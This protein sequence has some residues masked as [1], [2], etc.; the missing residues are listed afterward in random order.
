MIF[1][2]IIRKNFKLLIRSKASALIFLVGPLM[3]MLLISLAFN[4]SSLYDI[5]I[6]TYS[7]SY[8]ELSTSIIEKLQ[9]DAFKVVR[10]DSEDKCMESVK[11]G[12]IHVCAI[13]PPDLNIKSQDKIVFYV[14]KSRMNLI[15]VIMG[16]ISSKVS[17][18][19]TELSTLLTN[20]LVNALQKTNDI[21]SEK[22]ATIEAIKTNSMDLRDS[23]ANAQ[24]ELESIKFSNY[25]D[26]EK[27]LDDI[28]E[29]TNLSSSIFGDLED[30]IIQV[31]A[32]I[33]NTIS[34]TN[35]SISS[36]IKVRSSA[37]AQIEDVNKV[38]QAMDTIKA[39]IN[40]IEI[41]DVQ[42]IV[43][44]VSTEV[45]PVA[46]EGTHLTYSFSTLL[47]LVLMFA[48]IFMASAT[49]VEEKKSKAYF[50][51]FITPTK[52]VAFLFAD[53]I[54]CLFIIIFQI[55]LIF[56]VMGLITK[57]YPVFS[58]IPG[59]L[60]SLLL[61]ATIFILIGIIIGYVF[62]D[63][64]TSNIAS[65]S[66]STLLLFFS[67]T[68]LPIE[69]LPASIRQVVNFNPFMIGE[70][71]VRRVYMF[72]EPIS[73]IASLLYILGAYVAALIILSYLGRKFAKFR[74]NKI[75]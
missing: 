10:T 27:E 14:D 8:S 3:L 19:S 61:I 66:V 63:E 5:K 69:S 16:S 42:K 17:T 73:K 54:F 41:K 49:V 9:D 1:L 51:N 55:I 25:T 58:M 37:D 65:I 46:T 18:K 72:N 60:V 43:N 59:L 68:I 38:K 32:D 7:K 11:T 64:E 24:S 26:M 33:T 22:G 44:P 4:S 2:E 36:I 45:K 57:T 67:N 30:T 29:R 35:S 70:A 75:Q 20:T 71:A 23:A 28:K 62:R 48:G 15:W 53:Y 56:A 21:M 52:D 6:G 47:I 13:F 39:E 12:T 40:S 31:T 34:L 74:Y 50:R